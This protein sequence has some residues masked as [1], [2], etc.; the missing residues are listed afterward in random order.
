[1]IER[2]ETVIPEV[3]ARIAE[4]EREAFAGGGFDEWTLVPFIRH[5]RVYTIRQD[6][7]IVGVVEYMLDWESKNH[8]YLLGVSIDRQ[9]QGLGLGT[10]LLEVSLAELAGEGIREV[11]LTVDPANAAAVEV[12]DRKLGFEVV[13]YRENEYGPGVHRQVMRVA[14]RG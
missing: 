5:G 1:M 8:A 3:V 6:Q 11:E 10:R 4:I 13:D 14:L 2:L 12:Y 7:T 9:H